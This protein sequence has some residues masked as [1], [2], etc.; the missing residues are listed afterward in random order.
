MIA[1]EVAKKSSGFN[2]SRLVDYIGRRH[3]SDDQHVPVTFSNCMFPEHY[4]NSVKEMVAIQDLSKGNQDKSY[5]VVLSFHKQDNLSPKRLQHIENEVSKA[6]GYTEHQRVSA[7]HL[8]TKNPH[9]HIV[10]NKTHP[11]TL[12]VV[13][14]YYSQRKL[15]KVSERIQHELNL[16][17]DDLTDKIYRKDTLTDKAQTASTQKEY[18]KQ[19]QHEDLWS[20]FLKLKNFAEKNR[21]NQYRELANNIK[22]E[23]EQLKGK[24][25]KL[26]KEVQDDWLMSK[27]QKFELYQHLSK[28][29]RIQAQQITQKYKRQRDSLRTVNPLPEW[30]QFLI[31]KTVNGN[32]TALE[33]L[34]NAK[35]KKGLQSLIDK[36]KQINSQDAKI[37]LDKIERIKQDKQNRS[38]NQ[39]NI[40]NWIQSRNALVGKTA[41]VI[42]HQFFGRQTGE[43]IHSGTRKIADG[44]VVALLQKN[45]IMFV[46]P[47]SEK[48]KKFL[49]SKRK[50]T[51]IVIDKKGLF[52]IKSRN[53]K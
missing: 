8:D 49:L 12:R 31:E 43:F 45:G 32:D 34:V 26:R 36:L 24:F 20:A 51:K 41:D 19:K 50:G 29:R 4:N 1:K 27:K 6:L 39:Q 52:K 14:P 15:K 10:I 2:L 44:Q 30:Q 18:T 22:K 33:A 28:Q 25:D 40:K 16:K 48:Q 37:C 7:F 13:T 53:F 23:R 5:H 47:I 35:N 11:T 38:S 9:L 42:V 21:N 3:K 46:K 17:H